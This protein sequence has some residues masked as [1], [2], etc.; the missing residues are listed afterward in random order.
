TQNHMDHVHVILGAGRGVNAT[1]VGLPKAPLVGSGG[2]SVGSF[3]S[4][5]LSGGA[6]GGRGGGSVFGA[7]YQT[8][9]GT[10]GYDEDGR[11]GYY[12]PDP[13]QVREAEERAADAQQRIKDADAQVKIA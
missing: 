13:R 12:A 7:G 10:P 6:G 11:P 4:G 2:I 3:P 9:R 5:N 8:G 1:A